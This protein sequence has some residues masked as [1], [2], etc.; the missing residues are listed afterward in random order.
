MVWSA[1][2]LRTCSFR[3]HHDDSRRPG[4]SVYKSSSIAIRR[5][6]QHIPDLV[7]LGHLLFHRGTGREEY[8]RARR[9]LPLYPHRDQENKVTPA[10]I[11]P[12]KIMLICQ[13]ASTIWSSDR[14]RVSTR[15]LV[16]Q[17]AEEQFSVQCSVAACFNGGLNLNIQ[18]GR[19]LI[20]QLPHRTPDEPKQDK[21]P[22]N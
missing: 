14:N 7:L 20:G 4:R 17:A 9:A 5:C 15:A 16:L 18:I 11:G 6:P 12:Q 8:H 2:N 21:S 13:A 1:S 19:K 3:A 22:N 10:A